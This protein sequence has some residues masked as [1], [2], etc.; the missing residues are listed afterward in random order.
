MFVLK[1]ESKNPN[2]KTGGIYTIDKTNGEDKSNRAQRLRFRHY[3]F[4]AMVSEQNVHP[5]D[6]KIAEKIEPM[7]KVMTLLRFLELIYFTLQI[8]IQFFDF[9]FVWQV[10]FC[11]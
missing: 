11:L 9:D 6:C 4:H 3:D 10:V 8:F 2:L 5:R 7:L 1:P